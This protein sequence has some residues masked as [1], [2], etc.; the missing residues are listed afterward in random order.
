MRHRDHDGLVPPN[1]SI[2]KECFLRSPTGD[3][4][5]TLGG[6]IATC[7]TLYKQPTACQHLRVLIEILP[8]KLYSSNALARPAKKAR[9]PLS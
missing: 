6:A 3:P 7:S 8:Y 1:N 2:S 4:T 9:A 5:P